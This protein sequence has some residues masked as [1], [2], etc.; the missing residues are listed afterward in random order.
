MSVTHGHKNEIEHTP[1]RPNNK[2]I[3]RIYNLLK[4]FLFCFCDDV[5][6]VKPTASGRRLYAKGGRPFGTSAG[7]LSVFSF[8]HKTKEGD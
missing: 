3:K 5:M 6:M 7:T 4:R 8:S 2:L 1:P